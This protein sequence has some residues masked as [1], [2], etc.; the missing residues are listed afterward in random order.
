[1][2]DIYHSND[3][4]VVVDNNILVDLYELSALY[5][6]FELFQTVTIPTVIY[7]DEM[8]VDIK[9]E[10]NRFKFQ[11]GEFRTQIG[12]ETY[13]YLVNQKEYRRLSFL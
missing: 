8:I 7:E 5:L 9:L 13:A 10:L 4:S 1:M 3:I 2:I 11:K 6:L 12:H